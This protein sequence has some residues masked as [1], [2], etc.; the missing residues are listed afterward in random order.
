VE[1]GHRPYDRRL[2][3]PRSGHGGGPAA[4]GP[5]DPL[6]RA[7][8]GSRREAGEAPVAWLRTHLAGFSGTRS[9]KR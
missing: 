3:P 8:S 5:D 1:L 4:D 7:S 6:N 2:C 9:R